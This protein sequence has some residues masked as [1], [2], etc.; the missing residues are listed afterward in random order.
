LLGLYSDPH[1]LELSGKTLIAAELAQRYGIQDIDG[2]QPVSLRG[3]MGQPH[4]AF[5]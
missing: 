1:L 3:I 5:S 4:P 2:K